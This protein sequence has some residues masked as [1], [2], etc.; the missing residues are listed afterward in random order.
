MQR[1]L[2][3]FTG[4]ARTKGLSPTGA[5]MKM[6]R[7]IIHLDMDCF[8]CQVESVRLGLSPS[9]PLAVQQWDKVIAVNYAARAAGVTRHSSYAECFRTCQE[10]LL[11]HVPTYCTQSLGQLQVYGA[12]K[13]H[14]TSVPDRATHKAILQPYRE[15]SLKVFECIRNALQTYAPAA[16]VMEKASVDE[17]FVDISDIVDSLMRRDHGLSVVRGRLIRD[18]FAEEQLRSL[19]LDWSTCGR[20]AID[21]GLIEVAEREDGKISDLRI[22]L[23]SQVASHLR[24]H[25]YEEL[26][27]TVSAGIATNKTLA[28]LASARYKPNQQTYVRSCFVGAWMAQVPFQKIRFLGGKL[29]NMLLTSLRTIDNGEEEAEERE[30]EVKVQGGSADDDDEGNERD[31]LKHDPSIENDRQRPSMGDKPIMAADLWP[32]SLEELRAKL[33]GDSESARWAYGVIR[34]IDQTPV[35]PRLHTKSFMAAKQM[36]PPLRSWSQL[37]DWLMLLVSELVGRLAEERRMSG[38][39]PS[40]L[41]IH[42][43]RPHERMKSRALEFPYT[44]D[45]MSDHGGTAVKEGPMQAKLTEQLA[46]TCDK[47]LRAGEKEIPVLP[48]S[49]LALAVGRFRVVAQ[50]TGRQRSLTMDA[51]LGAETG[52]SESVGASLVGP[53]EQA[54]VKRGKVKRDLTSYFRVDVAKEGSHQCPK[55]E[56]RLPEN[57]WD[58]IQEHNDYHFALELQ[59]TID[60]VDSSEEQ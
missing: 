6:D 26:A 55:C 50:G 42:F 60:A 36:R 8:Y 53:A 33:G 34:G 32:L 27:Y 18:H 16:F 54:P 31:H 24:K 47:V 4:A 20:P 45:Q 5:S 23:G 35:A 37:H 29:G 21:P 12:T 25:V 49:M 13:H 39:W 1:S 51:F 46:K 38:R 52:K 30:I 9:L 28:K 14:D 7:V 59:N 10:L 3:H 48:C 56:R 15:A 19:H 2:D 22:F 57:D 43:A 17:V 58:T 11:V 41:T 44:S 40:S